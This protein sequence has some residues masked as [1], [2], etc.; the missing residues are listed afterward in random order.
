M[1]SKAITAEQLYYIIKVYPESV[2][3][4]EAEK[5]CAN[6]TCDKSFWETAAGVINKLCQGEK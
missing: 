6:L 3:A 5:A 2:S 1:A 4:E